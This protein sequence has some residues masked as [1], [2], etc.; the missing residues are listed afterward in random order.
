LEKELGK[1]FSMIL[2]YYRENRKMSLQE[3]SEKTGISVSYLD[4]LETNN[5]RLPGHHAVLKL[6]EALN[7]EVWR[8]M[9]SMM[10]DRVMTIA[11]LILNNKIQYGG[12]LLISEQK[13]VL[14]EI[15]ELLLD[16]EFSCQTMLQ[17]LRIIGEMLIKLKE[18]H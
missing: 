15:I 3:L 18:L 6:S 2:R 8:L 11:E 5:Y 13:V 1:E 7:V 14:I 4:K 17:D 12:E 9:G 16:V 10:Q